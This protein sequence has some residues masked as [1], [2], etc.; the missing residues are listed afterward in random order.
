MFV[1][2]LSQIEDLLANRLSE[3]NPAPRPFTALPQSY[4]L[5]QWIDV[6]DTTGQ[7]LEAQIAK[8]QATDIYV[9]YNGWGSR[10]DEWL[11]KGSDRVATFRTHTIQSPHAPFLSP[12]PHLEADA[13]DHEIPPSRPSLDALLVRYRIFA[14]IYMR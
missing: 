10:W 9:H 7:W 2:N 4:V 3:D 14:V 6:R 5:G 1:Q 11:P 12:Y 8:T 13:E